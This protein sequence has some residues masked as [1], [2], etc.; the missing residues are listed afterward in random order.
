MLSFVSKLFTVIWNLDFCFKK[1]NFSYVFTSELYRVKEGANNIISYESYFRSLTTA[2]MF[3]VGSVLA[4]LPLLTIHLQKPHI[5]ESPALFSVTSGD[6]FCKLQNL[7]CDKESTKVCVSSHDLS[8]SENSVPLRF[9]VGLTSACPSPCMHSLS[10][11]LTYIYINSL[12]EGT[13]KCKHWQFGLLKI[14]WLIKFKIVCGSRGLLAMH[15]FNAG[16]PS[17]LGLKVNT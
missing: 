9:M 16:L 12:S 5:P 1:W 13:Y 14:Q 6:K 4:L 3:S 2:W 15:R 8:K 11:P 17:F 10:F 7:F